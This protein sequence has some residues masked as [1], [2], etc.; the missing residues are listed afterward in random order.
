[1]RDL[2]TLFL[3]LRDLQELLR[4]GKTRLSARRFPLRGDHRVEVLNHRGDQTACRDVGFRA[5][6]RF[7]GG[8]RAVIGP[9][10]GRN[11][12]AVDRAPR[13]V[14]VRTVVGDEDPRRRAVRF[15]I[16]VL[17][18][19]AERWQQRRARLLTIL[20]R[21]LRRR[22][23]RAELLAVRA[24][25]RECALKGQRRDVARR[26]LGGGWRGDGD[27]DNR[28]QERRSNHDPLTI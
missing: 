28:T 19:T 1:M 25:L 26:R 20:R 9:F 11:Q 21:Q 8:R 3:T 17:H 16:D 5:R 12:V 4:L 22:Q 23:R 2:A 15:R 6:H 7:G 27:G 13:V 24:C 14:H 18:E 10:A